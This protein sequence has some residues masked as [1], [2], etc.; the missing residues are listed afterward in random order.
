MDTPA[1]SPPAGTGDLRWSLQQ[2][3]D[4]SVNDT[5]SAVTTATSG[6]LAGHL[7]AVGTSDH[8]EVGM[9]AAWRSTDGI[10]WQRV[11]LPD[12]ALAALQSV[13]HGPAGIV[14]V[15]FSYGTETPAPVAWHS[16]DGDSWRRIADPALGGGEMRAV[17]AGPNGFVALGVDAEGEG[18]SV[19]W[20]SADGV[21]WS[22]PMPVPTIPTGSTISGITATPDGLL[23]YGSLPAGQEQPVI[24]LSVD[25]SAW[26]QLLLP[27]PPG[28]V[29]N[30]IAVGDAGMV[31]VGGGFED[32][33]G[34][35]L[36]WASINGREWELTSDGATLGA[37]FGVAFTGDSFVAVGA[38]DL[39]RFRFDA[40]AWVTTDGRTWRATTEDES[41]HQARMYDVLVT[42]AG[43]VAVGERGLDDL[44]EELEPA[45]WSAAGE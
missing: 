26:E 44:A 33:P 42:T 45:I 21:S 23:A 39:A 22:G 12:P 7:F 1:P 27:G 37:M 32:D 10:S 25:G 4:F 41:F 29:V 30:D 35:V 20:T 36:T 2:G 13:A 9:A 11:D 24:W 17:A 43:V 5:I 19:A 15:G 40:A 38:R 16:A 3:Q 8:G 31:A 28:G 34:E 6:D 14:A 18:N